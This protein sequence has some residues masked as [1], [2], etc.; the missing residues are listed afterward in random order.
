MLWQG[1]KAGAGPG[2]PTDMKALTRE[3]MQGHEKPALTNGKLQFDPHAGSCSRVLR[4]PRPWDAQPQKPRFSNELLFFRIFQYGD[5]LLESGICTETSKE[6]AS[7]S[8]A[9]RGSFSTNR[10]TMQPFSAYRYCVFKCSTCDGSSCSASLIM[11]K[12][13]ND[14]LVRYCGPLNAPIRTASPAALRARS[15]DRESSNQY[16]VWDGTASTN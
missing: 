7:F 1:E 4:I 2:L 14:G 9:F 5:M 6:E 11:D 12:K 3:G 10:T 13:I 8:N 15:E 16:E